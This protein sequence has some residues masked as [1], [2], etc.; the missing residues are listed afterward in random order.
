MT[1]VEKEYKQIVEINIQ[2]KVIKII[3]VTIVKT[4]IT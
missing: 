2:R 4:L 3:Y 1:T